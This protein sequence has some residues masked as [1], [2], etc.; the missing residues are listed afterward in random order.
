MEANVANRSCKQQH[1]EAQKRENVLYTQE[2][3]LQDGMDIACLIKYIGKVEWTFNQQL[4]KHL[5][6]PVP[7][8]LQVQILVIC[9]ISCISTRSP[10]RQCVCQN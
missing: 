7:N 9:D 6:V 8:W 3:A 1:L 4:N 2:N 5:V 10:W